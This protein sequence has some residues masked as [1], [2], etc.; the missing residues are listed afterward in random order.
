[1]S[2][3]MPSF[4]RMAGDEETATHLLV[5]LLQNVQTSTPRELQ[6]N[7]LDAVSVVCVTLK[8]QKSKAA[9]ITAAS[10]F[11]PDLKVILATALDVE[12]RFNLGREFAS[13]DSGSLKMKW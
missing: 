2:A 12:F 10:E 13:S 7:V 4:H 6:E 11:Q 1:M 8:L 9:L 3:V 5:G